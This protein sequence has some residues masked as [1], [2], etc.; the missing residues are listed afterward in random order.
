M[1]G[2]GVRGLRIRDHLAWA[3][4]AFAPPI[5]ARLCASRR[6]QHLRYNRPTGNRPQKAFLATRWK[7]L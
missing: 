7:P 2:I 6:K 1:M 3:E 5:E 4:P